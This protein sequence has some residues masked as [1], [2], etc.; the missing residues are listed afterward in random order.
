MGSRFRIFYRPIVAKVET[1]KT[2]TK[3][4]V[5]LHNY[6]MSPNI[7]DAGGYCYC[8]DNFVD[9]EQPNGIIPGDW[10]KEQ[11]TNSGLQPINRQASNN[12]T[13]TAKIVRDNFKC[14]FNEE[15]AVSW[16]SEIVNRKK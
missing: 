4:V 3:A 5:A 7:N 8:P 6:L 14:Y 1:G 15:G 13:E 12:Y 11:V 9:Q 16:Q 10:R 2:I